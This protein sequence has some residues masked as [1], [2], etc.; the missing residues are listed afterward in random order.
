MKNIFK[1]K[2]RIVRD[3]YMGYEVQYKCWWFPF[4]VEHGF[5]NT[6]KTIEE[7]RGYID[8]IESTKRT[9]KIKYAGQVVE[10]YQPNQNKK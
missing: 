3:Q 10:Y 9:H 6:H 8:E 7:A 5:T 2:Y 4:W 1:T